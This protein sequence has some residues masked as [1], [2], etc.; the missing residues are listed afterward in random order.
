MGGVVPPQNSYVETPTP[1]V[2]V[3]GDRTFKGVVMVK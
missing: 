2:S 1:N 3:F